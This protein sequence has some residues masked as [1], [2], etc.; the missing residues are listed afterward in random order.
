MPELAG[1]F[2][3]IKMKLVGGFCFVT[4]ELSSCGDLQQHGEGELW[5]ERIPLSLLAR[6]FPIPC[7]ASEWGPT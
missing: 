6:T 4:R 1:P 7:C 2:E 3:M 5:A